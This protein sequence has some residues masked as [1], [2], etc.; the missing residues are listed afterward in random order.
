MSRATGKGKAKVKGNAPAERPLKVAPMLDDDWELM[1]AS[2]EA[3][4]KPAKWKFQILGESGECFSVRRVDGRFVRS[5]MGE[6]LTLVPHSVLLEMERDGM[7]KGESVAVCPD[8]QE[9]FVRRM[10]ERYTGNRQP[11]NR[12]VRVPTAPGQPVRG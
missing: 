3:A 8:T 2:F 4:R 1:A 11:R 10:L 5:C 12:P 7:G 6:E 9:G